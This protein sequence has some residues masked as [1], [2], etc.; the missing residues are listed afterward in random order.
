MLQWLNVLRELRDRSLTFRSSDVHFLLAQVITQAGPLS[1]AKPRLHDELHQ[2]G[3]GHVLVDEL[4]RLAADV[5]GN[6]LEGVRMN[7]ISLLLRVGPLLASGPD[8][9]VSK[10]AIEV[11]R[12]VRVKTFS[13]VKEL[14]DRLMKTPGDE[15]LRSLLR[16]TAVI[17]RSTFDAERGELLGYAEDVEILLSCAILIHDN[18][19]GILPS[20]ILLDRDCPSRDV[21]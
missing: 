20:G 12:A 18:H 15:E 5:E 11:L 16:D 10:R 17:Y 7:T 3:F 2:D 19:E 14:S 4:E 8:D 6:W 21:I 13:W 1:S 9:D